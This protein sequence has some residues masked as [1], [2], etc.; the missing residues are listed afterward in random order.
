[1]LGWT[2]NHHAYLA[3]GESLQIH[4]VGRTFWTLVCDHDCHRVCCPVTIAFALKSAPVIDALNLEAHPA[5]G[6]TRTVRTLTNYE[7]SAAIS[8]FKDMHGNIYSP[9]INLTD[10]K[11]SR[12][13]CAR[14]VLPA[15]SASVYARNTLNPPRLLRKSRN[16]ACMK[17]ACKLHRISDAPSRSIGTS[18]AMPAG[19]GFHCTAD[20]DLNWYCTA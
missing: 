7:Q 12:Q 14:A 10:G 2:G 1:M 16:Q 8:N 18:T 20:S 6:M 5:Q 17:C 19:L 13:S 3:K 9:C 4:L 15:Q 11:A